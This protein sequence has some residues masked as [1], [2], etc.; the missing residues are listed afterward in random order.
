[1]RWFGGC[2]AT[3]RACWICGATF[4]NWIWKCKQGGAAEAGGG[5]RDVALDGKLRIWW[6]DAGLPLSRYLPV[7]DIVLPTAA[8][9]EKTI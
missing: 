6:Y 1:M 7:L 8:R 4:G 3:A 5:W 9:Y 2:S